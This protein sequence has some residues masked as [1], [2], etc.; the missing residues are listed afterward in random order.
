MTSHPALLYA[1]PAVFWLDSPDRPTPRAALDEPVEADLVVV[2]GGFSGL[3]TALLA[4]QREPDRSVV[5]L[6]AEEIGW[7][8]S[9]RN[10]GFCS[11]SLTHGYENGLARFP[12]E[13][14]L[15]ERLGAENLDAIERTVAEFGIDCDFRRAPSLA[16]ATE[17]HQVPWLREGKGEFLDTEAVRGLVNSPTYLAGLLGDEP[18]AL[19]DPARLSW[20]LARAAEE[21]G[22]RIFENSGVTGLRRNGG[23]II[24]STSGAQVA[25]RK[26]A[27]GTN[28][29]PS[30]VRRTRLHTVPVYDYVLMTEPLTE[31]Q[32]DSVNWRNGAGIDDVANQFHYYRMTAD[33]RIL[34]GGYDAIYYFGKKIKA[35]YDQ[36]D[37]TFDKLAAQF[38]D[39]FPQLEGLRFTHRWGGAIDTCTR[40]CAFFGTAHRADVA[41]ATGYTG[42]GVGATRFGAEV[43]LDL[44][45]GEETERTRLEMVR[46]K[47]LPFPP[48]PLAYAGIQLTRRSLD[49][50]DRNEGRRGPWLR[51]LDRFG[52]GF[53]S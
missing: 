11:A 7:A 26:V 6:E 23:R 46:R 43:M 28:A 24:V 39:T 21:L 49:K 8:A 41:Y 19:V 36:R 38:F 3:W 34:W 12:H 35:E 18:L 10:G 14:D 25:A 33:N 5:L 22:V 51:T 13:I 40:F 52:L 32:R 45:A 27:L 37:A 53:D 42:L 31:A 4:K 17:P 2:G 29:F 1:E 16:V 20:G 44:L 47:P 50:A 48:E 30:L 15:L 9:G